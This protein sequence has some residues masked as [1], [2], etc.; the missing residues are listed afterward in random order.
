MN[1]RAWIPAVLLLLGGALATGLGSCGAPLVEPTAPQ[2]VYHTAGPLASPTMGV[3]EVEP[4]PQPTMSIHA[5]TPQPP[6]VLGSFYERRL[7]TVEWPR[8]L[9]EGDGDRVRLRLEVDEAGT[10]TPTVTVAGHDIH[11]QPVEIPN[12]YLTHDIYLQ[13]HLSAVGLQVEPRQPAAALLQPGQPVEMYWTLR[14]PEPGLYQAVLT[15]QL[16]LVP[17]VEGH[18]ERTLPLAHQLFQ[19][20]VVNFLGLSAF[21]VRLGGLFSTLL[22]VLLQLPDLLE[23]WQRLR[24]RDAPMSSP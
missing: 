7:L 24:G 8:R 12:L 3:E 14:G 17:K 13:A 16:H 23:V 18:R 22:G 6:Q 2:A 10:I 21:W 15:A 1:R 9:R 4:S 5:L 20:Q 19:V 11:G